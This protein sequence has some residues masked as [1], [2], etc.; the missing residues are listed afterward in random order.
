MNAK[1]LGLAALA[2]LCQLLPQPAAALAITDSSLTLSNLRV[3]AADP[4]A[5]FGFTA[6][7]EGFAQAA[8]SLGERH[9]RRPFRLQRTGL[10]HTHRSQCRQPPWLP[11][12]PW[13]PERRIFARA[14]QLFRHSYRHWRHRLG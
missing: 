2:L 6:T 3:S 4:N 9:R 13:H 5:V 8:N 14:R 12:R 10:R 11:E 1:N 7:G